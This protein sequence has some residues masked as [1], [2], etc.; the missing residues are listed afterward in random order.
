M[1]PR[2]IGGKNEGKM[3]ARMARMSPRMDVLDGGNRLG[4]RLGNRLGKKG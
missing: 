3:R 4:D 2:I 1:R